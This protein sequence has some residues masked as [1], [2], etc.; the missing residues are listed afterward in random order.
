MMDN[1]ECAVFIQCSKIFERCLAEP[2]E[3]FECL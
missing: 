2:G 3:A 1:R